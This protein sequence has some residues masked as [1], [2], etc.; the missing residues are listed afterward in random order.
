MTAIVKNTKVQQSSAIVEYGFN[1]IVEAHL[2][3]V[4]ALPKKALRARFHLAEI[5]VSRSFSE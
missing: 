5:A 2:G 1:D 3:L 4:E